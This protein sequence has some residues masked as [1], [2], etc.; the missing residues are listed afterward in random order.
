M[1]SDVGAI[2][3]GFAK[4]P[5]KNGQEGAA[6]DRAAKLK[7]SN[8]SRGSYGRPMHR[9]IDTGSRNY[10]KKVRLVVSNSGYRLE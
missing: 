5:V 10:K 3:I 8:T 4:V 6:Q 9:M 1:G 7:R 2:R